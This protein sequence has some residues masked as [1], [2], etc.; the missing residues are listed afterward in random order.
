MATLMT[1]PDLL[2]RLREPDGRIQGHPVVRGLLEGAGES[3]LKFG[4]HGLSEV[5]GYQLAAR[6]GVPVPRHQG[7]WSADAVEAPLVRAGPGRIGILLEFH[8]NYR[9]IAVEEFVNIDPLAAA[10]FLALC[11]FD[12]HEWGECGL[13][14]RV[15]MVVDLERILPGWIPDMIGAEGVDQDYPT[16]CARDYMRQSTDLAAETVKETRRLGLLS[17]VRAELRR[18]QRAID[19]R[20]IPLFR[21]DPHPLGPMLCNLAET[22]LRVRLEEGLHQFARR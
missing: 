16:R 10:R 21:L 8:A 7:F 18:L 1:I 14:G 6:F 4:E 19:S 2:N 20:S 13:V 22:A 15:P 12:R 17:A 3:I 5:L 9:P 11:L